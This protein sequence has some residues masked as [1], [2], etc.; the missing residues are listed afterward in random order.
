MSEG[1]A[2]V[3]VSEIEI[4]P[5]MI[6]AG[7]EAFCGY[8]SRF[9]GPEDVVAEIFQAMVVASPMGPKTLQALRV[10]A[11]KLELGHRPINPSTQ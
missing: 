10:P 6:E 9:E 3:D 5:E 11:N 1:I 2:N 7:T 4:T 8:D